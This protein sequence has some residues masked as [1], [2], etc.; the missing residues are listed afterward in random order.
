MFQ[1]S[2]VWYFLFNDPNRLFL[3]AAWTTLWISVVAQSTG[4][5]LGLFLAL[6]RMSRYPYLS[7]PARAFV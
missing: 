2:T 1:W 6:M 5:I 4:V 3:L 7:L